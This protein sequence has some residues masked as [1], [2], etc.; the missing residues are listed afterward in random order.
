M[1]RLKIGLMSTTAIG[2]SMSSFAPAYDAD[3]E[4]YFDGM[5]SFPLSFDEWLYL[6]HRRKGRRAW[7]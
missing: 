1:K 2:T 3:F 4:A 7:H 6:W 5:P